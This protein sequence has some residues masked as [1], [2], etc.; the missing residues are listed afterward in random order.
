MLVPSISSVTVLFN[1]VRPWADLHKASGTNSYAPGH[2]ASF[3]WQEVLMVLFLPS[4]SE[5]ISNFPTSICTCPKAFWEKAMATHSSTLA[6]RIPWTEEPG[7]L[8]SMGSRRVGH[9]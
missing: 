8:Q 6:W 7:R 1:S 5:R 9:D 2:L 3:P 4:K